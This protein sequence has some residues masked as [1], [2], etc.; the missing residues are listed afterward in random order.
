S[1]HDI[2]KFIRSL[3]MNLSRRMISLALAGMVASVLTPMAGAKEFPEHPIKI[4]VPYNAG[5]AADLVARVLS[6]RLAATTGASFVVEN[7]PGAGGTLGV[8]QVSKAAPD[9]Y[10]LVMATIGPLSLAPHL[11][12]KLP[13][14]PM[15][16]LAPITNIALTP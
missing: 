1:V 9:G 2:V 3:S 11:Y 8:N 16:D 10:T 4:V 5:Q 7:K 15:T 12:K 6:A 14:S 13:Y